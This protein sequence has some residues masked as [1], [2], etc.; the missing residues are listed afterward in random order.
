M[1]VA[2]IRKAQKA[3][4]GVSEILAVENENDVQSFVDEVRIREKALAL[5]HELREQ[6][7]DVPEMSL[8]EINAEIKAARAEKRMKL[9]PVT[10]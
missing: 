4:A 9:C 7:S 1:T 3:F 10:Q 6:A 2:A 8:E 5:F